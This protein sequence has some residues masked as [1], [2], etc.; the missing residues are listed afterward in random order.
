MFYVTNTMA[1]IFLLVLLGTGIFLMKI[2]DYPD[3]FGHLLTLFLTLVAFKLVISDKLPKVAYLTILD[4]FTLMGF[5]LHAALHC[6]MRAG[7]GSRLVLAPDLLA[8]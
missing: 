4:K 1:I 7:L 5:M 6:L 2:E 8:Q 3:R